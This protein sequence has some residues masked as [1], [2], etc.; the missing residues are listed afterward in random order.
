[1][2]HSSIAESSNGTCM[3]QPPVY[4]SIIQLYKCPVF[5]S[6]VFLFKYVTKYAFKLKI[7]P[8]HPY[9]T[10]LGKTNLIFSRQI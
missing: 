2:H 6:I 9:P 10:V 8:F 4:I 3:K 1:M 7:T 5:K